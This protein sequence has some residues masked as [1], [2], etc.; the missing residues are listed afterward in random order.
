MVSVHSVKGMNSLRLSVR[1]LTKSPVFTAVAVTSLALGIGA[2]TAIFT[3]M[4]QVLLRVLP[5]RE[6]ERIVQLNEKGP[7][8]G[9]TRGE[10]AFSYPMY[11]DVRDGNVVFDGVIGRFPTSVGLGYK[12]QT[13]RA[14]AEL[15]TGNYFD[16]LGLRAALGRLLTQDDDRKPDAHPVAVLSYGY[17]KRKF[18]GDKG[19]LQ[20]T[21]LINNHPMTVI[22]VAQPGFQGVEVGGATDVFLPVM[23][24]A[25]ATPTWNSLEDRRDAWLQIFARLKR[26]ISQ[27]QAQASLEP[28]FK[29]ILHNEVETLPAD[30]P[31]MREVFL[32]E[33]TL[34]VESAS[35]GI[36]F[37]RRSAEKPLWVLMAMVGLVLLIACAN[38]AN[39]LTARAAARQREIA[40]RAS[41]GASR[42]QV[43][44]QL[45]LESAVLSFVGGCFALLVAVWTGDLLLSSLPFDETPHAFSTA[46][47]AR[48]L[49]FNFAISAVAALLFGLIPAI[50]AARQTLA[51]TLK[52]EAGN[53]SSA[54]GQV[55]LRKGL[56]V[57]QIALSL[58]L[59]IG[60]GLF[61]RS[62]YNLRSLNPGFVA[63]NLMTFSIEP[64]LSGYE[65]ERAVNFFERALQ[66]L[67]AIPGVRLTSASDVPIMTPNRAGYTLI[68]EGY[69]AKEREDMNADVNHIA[70]AFFST[71]G[72][73]II[74][75][76]EFTRADQRGSAPVCMINETMVKR[77]FPG[78]NPIGRHVGFGRPKVMREIVGIVKDQ[79]TENLRDETRRHVFA[80]LLQDE[81]PT[82]ATLYLRTTL[83]PTAVATA[84]RREMQQLDV[85]VPVNS[86][87]TMEVQVSESLFMERLI[88]MLSAFFGLLATLLAA[89]GLYGVMAYSVAR[90]TRE[91]GIRVALGAE[92]RGVIAMVMKEVVLLAGIGVGVGLPVA[93]A[94]TAYVQ[95]QLFG[96]KPND[97]LTLSLAVAVMAGVALLAGYIPA[98][99]AA[100][101][102]PIVALRYE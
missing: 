27:Q 50:Q 86:M 90:R 49:I 57:A 94:L 33:K 42:W 35:R 98:E 38:V 29:Q 10:M 99:R 9:T 4:D 15:V 93:L 101:V 45:L 75:G 52:S 40:I 14:N 19:I 53:L 87:K 79:K 36:S 5:I 78:Q 11:R 97:P 18:G 77:F 30:R 71:I 83:A 63:Q 2:N 44:R 1:A 76:R 91:I 39:L 89:I 68:V 64:S 6:P 80:P 24:K 102:D 46:P 59:L 3:L 32:K 67:Q 92:R 13:E 84:I 34:T 81:N 65:R 69:T 72:V 23:M 55:R 54:S 28:L 20:N 43:V 48:V 16:V 12:G 51:D 56:V 47:D 61:A 88:A 70:P 31:Q 41:L 21:I 82:S 73:P 96:L 37:L 85:N 22:G 26:G 95:T 25:Q 60:A 66:S 100:R 58:L 7:R 8:F 17:W 62:L 74:A